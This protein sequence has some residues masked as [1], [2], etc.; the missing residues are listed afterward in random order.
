M[1]IQGSDRRRREAGQGWILIAL[2]VVAA[3]SMLAGCAVDND[4]GVLPPGTLVADCKGCHMSKDMLVAT[5]APDTLPPPESS[6][7]G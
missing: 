7:E 3:A 5:A 6:G 1:R 2:L 4:G